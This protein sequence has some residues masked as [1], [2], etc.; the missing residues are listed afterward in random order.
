MSGAKGP[1]IVGP[2]I[3]TGKVRRSF[4][5]AARDYDSADA[6]QTEV[7]DRLLDR[8]QWITLQP[9]RVL[10]LGTGTGKALPALAGRFPGAELIGLDLSPGMLEVAAGRGDGGSGQVAALVCGDAAR[11]PFADQSFD[12]VFANLAIHWSPALDLVFREVRRVLRQPGLFTFSAPGPDSYR[13][14]RAA[15]H[16]VDDLPHVMPFPDMQSLGDG[17]VRARLVEPVLDTE[18]LT[19]TYRHFPDLVRDLRSTGTTNAS[20]GRQPGL[21]GRHSW[22]RVTSAYEALRNSEGLLPATVEVVFGQAWTPDPA[23]GP[24]R[25]GSRLPP[26]D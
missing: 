22:A 26:P 10:D 4:S 24:G 11:L 16:A 9:R 14:L 13:E 8:L 15:W 6:L 18:T 21:T 25:R 17:M 12:L 2:L 3:D 20:R 5:R 23:A 7:R 19:L 1:A